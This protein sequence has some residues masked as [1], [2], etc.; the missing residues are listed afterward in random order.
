MTKTPRDVSQPDVTKIRE[1]IQETR[2]KLGETAEALARK[3]DVPARAKEK[4]A[5]VLDTTKAKAG[6]VKDK[7]EQAMHVAQAKAADV[8]EQ[9]QQTIDKLP[10][11]A[12]K[13]ILTAIQQRPGVF[14][15]G[16]IVSISL[17]RR[18][19]RRRRQT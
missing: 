5:E 15:V 6:V 12:A 18:V 9:A 4:A 17:L 10:P 3:V 2:Q 16:V 19:A 11:S 14:L 1:D 7:A 13:R 8:S